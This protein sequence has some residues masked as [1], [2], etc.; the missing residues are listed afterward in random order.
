MRP[1]REKAGRLVE[2]AAHPRARGDGPPLHYPWLRKPTHGALRQSRLDRAL[3]TESA[4]REL[5]SVS[6]LGLGEGSWSAGR[7]DGQGRG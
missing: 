7:V 4:G 5:M 1:S 6:G 3:V 2:V